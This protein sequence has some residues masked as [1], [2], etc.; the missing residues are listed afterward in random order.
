MAWAV[1]AHARSFGV[2]S[3][4]FFDQIDNHGNESWV[5]A[6]GRGSHELDPLFLAHIRCFM[7]EVKEDLHVIRNETQWLDNHVL[8]AL[9]GVQL[10]YS[11]AYIRFKPGLLGW[12]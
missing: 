5:Q 10:H 1:A 7:I 11:I 6:N 8:D 2:R 9:F 12:S 3:K 4:S